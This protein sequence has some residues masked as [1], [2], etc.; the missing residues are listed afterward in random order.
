MTT[1]ESTR[2]GPRRLQRSRDDR[3]IAG[4]CGGIARY[5]GVDATIVRV[6]AVA[7]L[8]FGGFGAFLYLAAWLLVPDQGAAR[9]LLGRDDQRR[10]VRIA[11]IVALALVAVVALGAWADFGFLFGGWPL[12][13]LVTG[14]ALIWF[15][16][17]RGDTSAPMMPA[18]ATRAPGDTAPSA[19][20]ATDP[21]APASGDPAAPDAPTLVAEA[22]P[23]DASPP[24][25]PR[26]RRRRGSWRVTA[27]ASGG[28]F[29]LLAVAGALDAL[30]VVEL[31]WGGMV[32]L[33]I[34]L[35][36]VALV[37]SA[38]FGG[39]RGLIPVG[40]LLAVVLGGAA[41]TG[42]S[43]NGGVGERDY[44]VTDGD[45][46]RGRYELGIGHLMLDLR[47]IEL[48]RGVTRITADLDFGMLEIVAPGARIDD[49]DVSM[50]G[51]ADGRGEG[52]IDVRRTIVVGS[53]D[54]RLE[55]DAHVGAGLVAVSTR[56]GGQNWGW[57]D[58]A[59]A[60]PS[61]APASNRPACIGLAF[62]AAQSGCEGGHD[63]A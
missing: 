62:A 29:L 51:D 53:G 4:V 22:G 15:V 36:G 18:A 2:N 63:A 8:A 3:V 59:P 9:P 46:L 45:L 16:T 58:H 33:A 19:E 23:P 13:L 60:R 50:R 6:V 7:L 30:D 38:F 12:L 39:A 27:L 55:I 24:P 26:E 25:P 40:I 48:A 57:S 34:V 11:G 41:A 43:L 31:G 56:P 10:G 35:I 28:V 47:G 42:V 21:V 61:I 32:A 52:G 49:G 37:A 5:F 17:E 44:R 20:P 1:T 14:G 54:R